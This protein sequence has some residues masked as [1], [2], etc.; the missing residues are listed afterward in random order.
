[1]LAEQGGVCAVCKAVPTIRGRN[2]FHVDHDH[3][4]GKVRAILCYACNSA[5]GLIRESKEI[6]LS[7]ASYIDEYN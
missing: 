5:L 6:A 7:L 1:M 4:T 2:P 3:V